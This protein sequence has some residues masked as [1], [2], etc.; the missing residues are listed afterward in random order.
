[1]TEPTLSCSSDG[2]IRRSARRDLGRSRS[3]LRGRY[4]PP[5]FLPSWT[6]HGQ[7][8]SGGAGRSKAR[9]MTTSALATRSSPG[10][11]RATS[12]GEASTD[13]NTGPPFA[14]YRHTRSR[15]TTPG[16]F[17]SLLR[18]CNTREAQGYPASRVSLQRHTSRRRDEGAALLLEHPCLERP[19]YLRAAGGHLV[20]AL[21]LQG[22][23]AA[24]GGV[25][26]AVRQRQADYLVPG[27]VDLL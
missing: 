6:N 16:A 20:E 4:Q 25:E 21:E 8:W 9:S 11:G 26:P 12:S 19:A 15:S 24:V 3:T 7:T 17:P 13:P 27:G 5:R 2:S 22:Q 1:M 23:V 10:S 18:G 14:S